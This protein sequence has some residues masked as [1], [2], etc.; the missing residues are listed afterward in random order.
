MRLDDDTLAYQDTGGV[1]FASV[2]LVFQPGDVV[3]TLSHPPQQHERRDSNAPSTNNGSTTSKDA[4][5]AT[6]RLFSFTIPLVVDRACY[7]VQLSELLPE[8]DVPTSVTAIKAAFRQAH[9]ASLPSS[10][11]SLTTSHSSKESTGSALLQGFQLWSAL[12]D[13][14][15]DQAFAS[16][17][18]RDF[19][20]SAPSD[21]S[22]DAQTLDVAPPSR[23][24]MVFPAFALRE[25][26]LDQ[27]VVVVRS[28]LNLPKTMTKQLR[29]SCRSQS[30]RFYVGVQT[31][32]ANVVVLRLGL[33]DGTI[34]MDGEMLRPLEVTVQCSSADDLSVVRLSIIC[35][36]SADEARSIE[37]V[38]L[39]LLRVTVDAR[40]AARERPAVSR[41]RRH[42]DAA[43]R[44]LCR[45]LARSGCVPQST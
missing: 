16:K 39:T 8:P 37:Y 28:V 15:H 7:L 4:N 22:A 45:A 23:F 13:H 38:Q 19:A 20:P 27:A 3:D 30:G 24:T 34:V 6:Q 18:L 35:L 12:A 31:F 10:A 9:D 29:A 32:T 36:S 5:E 1:L 40:A 43:R 14:W 44:S 25:L 26:T 21:H 17:W 2:S 42:G 33:A 11:S 41:A